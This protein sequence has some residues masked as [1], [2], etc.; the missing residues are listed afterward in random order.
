MLDMVHDWNA[1]RTVALCAAA[2]GQTMFVLLY[3]TFPWYKTFLGRSLFG[4]AVALL[5]I[6]D[7]AAL[8]RLFD[9]GANDVV[10]TLM[11][12]SLA[13]GVWWQFHSFLRVRVDGHHDQNTGRVSGN[14][15]NLDG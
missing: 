14:R 15:V 3:A 5:V 6:M 2:L 11:Y 13:I 12:G 10:F 1:Y 7:F 4:K 8:S 9:F